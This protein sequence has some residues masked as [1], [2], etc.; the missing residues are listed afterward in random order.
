MTI[1]SQAGA[2]AGPDTRRRWALLLALV[3]LAAFAIR[4][5][6]L[7]GR[8]LWVDEG[9]TWV[10]SQRSLADLAR[11]N[12]DPEHPPGYYMLIHFTTRVSDSEAGLRFPSV[13]ASTLSVLLVYYL[14]RRLVDHKTGLIAAAL[15]ALSP[16][17][18]WYAQEARHPVFA[19]LVVVAA[20]LALE[21]GKLAG[22][23]AA[24]VLLAVG[25][26]ID[27]ITAAGW[28]ALGGIWVALWWRRDRTRL[29][30]WAV[31][32]VIAAAIYAP[33]QGR[34][35]LDG[36]SGLL[37]YEGAGIW[38]GEILGSNPITSNPFGLLFLGGVA[39]WAVVVLGNRITKGRYGHLFATIAVFGFAVGSAITFI[40]RAYS[41]KKVIVT[42]WPVIVL[43]IAFLIVDRVAAGRRT[44][45]LVAALALSAIGTI[46]TF[47]IPKDDWR[48][49]TAFVEERARPGDVV[50][51]RQEPWSADAY[52]YYGGS[53]PA[54]YDMEP[55]VDDAVDTVWMITYRRPQDTPPALEAERW[56]DENWRFEE[57]APFYRLAVRKYARP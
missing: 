24:V 27:F 21:R 48:G 57:E 49:A 6:D 10:Q 32:T 55:V 51:V 36:F 16:L 8:S 50:W 15:L 4:L 18:V 7:G 42:G 22:K 20:A 35:F 19:A 30:D 56:F 31:V 52:F 12:E 44:P 17:D 53:L 34:Q 28:A 47:T 29:V 9:A 1:T 25:L 43:L 37:T 41:V 54:F 3:V 2:D 46:A 40:P 26:Y 11:V 39:I 13:V 5:V 23:A 45:V 14:G 33:I 38:Y